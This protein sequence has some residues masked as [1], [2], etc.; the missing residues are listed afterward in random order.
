MLFVFQRNTKSISELKLFHE[1]DHV[2]VNLCSPLFHYTRWCTLPLPS[3]VCCSSPGLG[4][5]K[6]GTTPAHVETFTYYQIHHKK[7]TTY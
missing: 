7:K 4:S 3:G 5:G 2:C 6:R 1:P